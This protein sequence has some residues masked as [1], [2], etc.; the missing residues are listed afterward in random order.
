M[1]V[2]KISGMALLYRSEHSCGP[3]LH[4]NEAGLKEFESGVD[5]NIQVPEVEYWSENN[6][7]PLVGSR[8]D[9]EKRTGYAPQG[10]GSLTAVHD[11][12]KGLKATRLGQNDLLSSPEGRIKCLG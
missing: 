7:R 11:L 1:E 5:G 10:S 4:R 8:L 2:A 12:L 9:Y 3:R 6:S